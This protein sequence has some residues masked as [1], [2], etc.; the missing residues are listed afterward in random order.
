ALRSLAGP[1]VDVTVPATEVPLSASDVEELVAITR[2]ALDDTARHGADTWVLVEDLDE[3][4]VLTIRRDGPA[5]EQPAA[6]AA[7]GQAGI[8]RS[9]RGRVADLGGTL[10]VDTR[11]GQGTEWKVRLTRTRR[12]LSR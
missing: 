5:D 3:E 4:V 8:A 1:R 11:P 7:N 10:T 12:E 6:V 9:I 2:E